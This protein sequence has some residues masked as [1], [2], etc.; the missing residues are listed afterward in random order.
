MPQCSAICESERVLAWI[1]ST[2]STWADRRLPIP[3]Q[4]LEVVVASKA[5]YF[6]QVIPLTPASPE[7]DH[8][9]IIL[10][11]PSIYISHRSIC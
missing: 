11:H 4:V 8:G 3:R 9:K 5:W 7:T 1:Q 6:A 10:S 2:V